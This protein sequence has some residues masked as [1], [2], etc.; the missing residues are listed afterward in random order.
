MILL[1]SKQPGSKYIN[2]TGVLLGHCTKSTPKPFKPNVMRQIS[3]IILLVLGLSV[4]LLAQD[5]TWNGSVNTDWNTADNWTPSGV[6]TA[7]NSLFIDADPANQPTLNTAATV[8]AVTIFGTL[9]IGASGNLTVYGNQST[10]VSLDIFGLLTNN[11]TI[12]IKDAP[13]GPGLNSEVYIW[14]GQIVNS[15][16]ITNTYAFFANFRDDGGVESFLNTATGVLSHSGTLQAFRINHQSNLTNRGLIESTNG[17]M[18][19]EISAASHVVNSGTMRTNSTNDL[20]LTV[21]TSSFTNQA[22]GIIENG[23]GNVTATGGVFTNDG[24]IQT[25]GNISATSTFNNSGVLAATSFTGVTGAGLL[26]KNTAY[27]DPIFT[28]GGGAYSVTGIFKNAAA[29]ISAGTFVA[30]NDFTPNSTTSNLFAQV[31]NGTCNF[32]VPFVYDASGL[33]VSLISFTGQ[34]QDKNNLLEWKTADEQNNAGFEIE[35]SADARTFEKIGAVDGGG[36]SKVTRVYRFTDPSPF[37]ST[38]YRLKQIDYDGTYNYSRIISVKSEA[39][40]FSIYPNPAQ[41]QLFVKNLESNTEV[42]I[43]DINGKLLVK[44]IV[45]PSTPIDIQSLPS[46]LFLL[47]IGSQ[48]QKLVIQK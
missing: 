18:L 39:A 37:S 17:G 2:V 10:L 41:N 16:T 22:C 38:Y 11:G 48:R 28:Y 31:G 25:T 29:T 21:G 47:R 7:S 36:D 44:K 32:V 24:M 27:P 8:R 30:P 4:N 12:Q 9:T 1:I 13:S 5:K 14:S 45:K 3:T 42:A 26:I 15:G 33:P 43:S 40:P 35:K 46:G 34:N 20:A 6:P 23:S 19:M